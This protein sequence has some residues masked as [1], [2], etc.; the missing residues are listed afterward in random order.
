MENM[1]FIGACSDDQDG[2]DYGRAYVFERGSD[3]NW[4]TAVDGQLY[5][6][7]AETLRP[8][9]PVNDG[10]GVA[11]AIDGNNIIIASRTKYIYF[12]KEIMMDG[13]MRWLVILLE[14]TMVPVSYIRTQSVEGGV[15]I[16]GNYAIVGIEGNRSFLILKT[17]DNGESWELL[18][19]IK[20]TWIN[21]FGF[22][23]HQWKLCYR[24]C[25]WL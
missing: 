2:S 13:V 19:T 8:V 5:R 11:V 20:N 21:R 1:L 25:T 10:F 14:L 4:G 16:D 24:W 22:K 15:D 23:F 6:A 3:G 7:E 17:N 9:E 18:N 12:L